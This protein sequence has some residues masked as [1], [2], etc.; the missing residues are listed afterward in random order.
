MDHETPLT[1]IAPVVDHCSEFM[2]D[3]NQTKEEYERLVK[4]KAKGYE[5]ILKKT[6]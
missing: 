1:S 6:A 2:S 5:E 3:M 4:E